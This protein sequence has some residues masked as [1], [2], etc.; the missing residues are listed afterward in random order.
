[1]VTNKCR[2]RRLDLAVV[3]DAVTEAKIN[4]LGKKLYGRV[5][6]TY[7]VS[8]RGSFGQRDSAEEMMP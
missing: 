7:L 4:K 2:L 6:R 8:D 1:M 3:Q 5:C